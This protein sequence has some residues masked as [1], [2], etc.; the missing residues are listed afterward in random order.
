MKTA[1]RG[2]QRDVMNKLD[3]PITIAFL[4]CYAD[5]VARANKALGHVQENASGSKNT[6]AIRIRNPL[7]AALVHP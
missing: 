7:W 1:G 3:E 5:F 2:D 6:G 4:V